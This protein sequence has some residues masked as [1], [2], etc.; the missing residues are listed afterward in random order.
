MSSGLEN[1]N[2]D[3]AKD[4][5]QQQEN[6]FPL[7]C[8]LLIPI[9]TISAVHNLPQQEKCGGGKVMNHGPSSDSELLYCIL[10]MHCRLFDIVLYRIEQCA[11]IDD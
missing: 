4:D 3:E 2:E 10:H 1:K 6:A 5:K 9:N 8:A 7:S 11:L